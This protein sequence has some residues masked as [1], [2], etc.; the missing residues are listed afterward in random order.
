MCKFD[1]KQ[2]DK[3]K[4]KKKIS[5]EVWCKQQAIIRI[6]SLYEWEV[7]YFFIMVCLCS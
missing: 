7:S 2:I 6:L 5:V 4:K 1:R 3:K